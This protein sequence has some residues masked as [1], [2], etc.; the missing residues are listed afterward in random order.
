MKSASRR[1][2]SKLRIIVLGYIVRCPLGG[3]AWHYMQYV[4]GLEQLGH[5]VYFVEDSDDYPCCYD[6]VRHIVDTDPSHGLAFT[7]KV[8]ERIGLAD[9]WAYY[10]AHRDTWH[11][12]R[13]GDIVGICPTAD[14]LLNISGANPVRPWLE[15]IPIR[16][17]I[18]TDPVFEQIRQMTVPIRRER[19]RMHTHFFTFGENIWRPDT[20]IPCDGL[21]W[22]ATRQ[23]VV[24]GRWPVEPPPASGRFTTVMQWESYPAREYRGTE[25]GLKSMSFESFSD[26]PGRADAS[27]ELALGSPS[28]PRERLR[29]NGWNLRN[30]LEV[31][32]DPW[33]YQRYIRDSMAEFTVAKHGY[34]IARSGW[35]SERSAGYLAS[36]RPVL[37]QE[38]GFSDWLPSGSGVL[39]FSTLEEAVEGVGEIRDRYRHHCHAARQLAE[40]Y[41]DSDKVLSAMVEAA[42]G[43]QDTARSGE[44]P[45]RRGSESVSS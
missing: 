4:L 11:G 25:Y 5:D 24:L 20:K 41:F 43:S 28:A 3:M 30:P 17:F 9:R 37:T 29:A 26:L 35:F 22:K 36:G 10:D 15:R 31:T 44:V 18:D 6:P 39:P 8:F 12:P 34:V 27:F 21:D 23:P 13:G 2:E 14:L 40:D 1:G 7:A 16:I 42:A 32:L 19:A 45:L 33:T 38:T